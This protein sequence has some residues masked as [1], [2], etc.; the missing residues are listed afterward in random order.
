M[1]RQKSQAILAKTLDILAKAGIDIGL[2]RTG[3]SCGIR[4]VSASVGPRDCRVVVEFDLE[5]ETLSR[6]ITPW[7]E[8]KESTGPNPN[9]PEVWA[10]LILGNLVE[11]VASLHTVVADTH[12]DLK[13]MRE[14]VEISDLD[15]IEWVQIH[16]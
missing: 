3:G 2:V 15:L 9:R 10:E 16:Y 12:K 4:V 5:G 8:G 14:E 11:W 6:T 13:R 1:H 7:E